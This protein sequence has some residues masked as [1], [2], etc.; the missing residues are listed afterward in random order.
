[1]HLLFK[2]IMKFTKKLR[3]QPSSHVWSPLNLHLVQ[4]QL[5]ILYLH[6]YLSKESYKFLYRFNDNFR[7][8]FHFQNRTLIV[9]YLHHQNKFVVSHSNCF[10]KNSAKISK[11]DNMM[12][13]NDTSF[14]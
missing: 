4:H 9:K 7:Q 5:V 11:Q 13:V 6:F 8:N 10:E 2:T 1:M 14:N 12:P 3:Y